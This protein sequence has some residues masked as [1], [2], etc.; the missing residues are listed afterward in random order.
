MSM[1]V[2]H[3]LVGGLCLVLLSMLGLGEPVAAARIGVYFDRDD[4]Q[5]S[6]QVQ[7]QEQFQYYVAASDISGNLFAFECEVLIPPEITVTS[8]ALGSDEFINIGQG[9]NWIVGTTEVQVFGRIN[10]IEY[11]ALLLTEAEGLRID[12][13]PAQSAESPNRP[14][15]VTGEFGEEIVAEFDDVKGAIINADRK[16]WGGLKSEY[17]EQ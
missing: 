4:T 6:T 11:T 17:G 3:R 13:G 16:S 9:D 12:L 15:Y 7:V 8:R 1:Q 14:R 2:G 10:L 5:S